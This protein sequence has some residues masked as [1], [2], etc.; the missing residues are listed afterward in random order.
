MTITV[1]DDGT[2][3]FQGADGS[4]LPN[5][6]ITAIKRQQGEVGPRSHSAKVRPNQR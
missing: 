1:E 5:N 2:V 4:P 6:V 3:L